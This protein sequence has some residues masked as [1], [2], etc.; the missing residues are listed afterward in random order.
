MWDGAHKELAHAADHLATRRDEHARPGTEVSRIAE[1]LVGAF[2]VVMGGGAI[3]G[4]A[5]ARWKADLNENAKA[6]AAALALPEANHNDLCAWAAPNAE[7]AAVLL[8][9]ADEH[10]RVADR[11]AL[12]R[13]VFEAS[14]Q[15]VIDVHAE[16]ET[17]FGR[18]MDLALAG[19]FVSLALADALGVDAE[20]IPLIDELKAGLAGAGSVAA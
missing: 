3:G 8:R 19:S 20:P 7:L 12:V 11:F 14:C 4:T 6:Q 10:P 1:R 16:G 9:H 17:P 5:A 18:L 15:R 13:P 2:P